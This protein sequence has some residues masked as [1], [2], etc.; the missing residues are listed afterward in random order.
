MSA[1]RKLAVCFLVSASACGLA[2][3]LRAWPQL[4]DRATRFAGQFA[5][6]AAGM[7]AE[8]GQAGRLLRE[9]IW[10]PAAEALARADRAFLDAPDSDAHVVLAL[11]AQGPADGR[12]LAHVEMPKIER[13]KLIEAPPPDLHVA[14]DVPLSIAPDLPAAPPEPHAAP[15]P[16]KLA[17]IPHAPE[18]PRASLGTAALTPEQARARA[19]LAAM[20]TPEMRDNF[21]LFIFVSKSVK[22]PLAQR[23][24]VFAKEKSTLTLLHDWAASTGREKSE[25]SPRGERSFTATP[26]GLYQF[27]P[28]RMYRAYHSTNW[29]QDMPYAM[30]FNWQREGLQTGLAIHAASGDDIARLGA[31]ASAGCVHLSPENARTLFD[32]VKSQY[33]GAVPR[34]AIDGND[35]MSSKGKFSHRAD[36]SLRM[37]QGYRVLIDIEDY[38]GADGSDA[39]ALF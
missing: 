39:V 29:D 14:V 6:P 19:H 2:A 11:K 38:S 31:R 20:L 33:R 12:T 22:G 13:P 16:A 1:L 17:E 28:D 9:K 8:A 26:A 15:K 3:G 4:E 18:T 25:V 37:A 24:Y 5:N 23:M 10:R 36:G 7:L 32:L 27:D 35:T 34:F 30:F 21:G